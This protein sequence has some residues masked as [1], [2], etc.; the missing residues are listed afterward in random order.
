M[1]SN[2]HMGKGE[3]TIKNPVNSKRTVSWHCGGWVYTYTPISSHPCSRDSCPVLG[4]QTIDRRSRGVRN[5]L[6]HSLVWDPGRR[7]IPAYYSIL[8]TT[9]CIT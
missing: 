4:V 8:C 1:A 5:S 7:Y 2:V 6:S 3:G 9:Q